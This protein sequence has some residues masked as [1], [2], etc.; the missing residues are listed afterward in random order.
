MLKDDEVIFSIVLTSSTEEV[1]GYL[2]LTDPIR[3]LPTNALP[4]QRSMV[5][6]WCVGSLLRIL[7]STR[8]K[9]WLS[10]SGRP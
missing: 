2:N 4:I 7:R 1:S 10:L 3:E 6:Y 8:K 5:P 9:N